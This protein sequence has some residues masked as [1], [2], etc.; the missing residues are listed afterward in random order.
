LPEGARFGVYLAYIYYTNL[1]KKIRSAPADRV[2]Q[3]R[4]RVPN[5]RKAVLLFSSAL[6][7]SLNL[8]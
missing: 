8:L 4:I 2:T 3:E 5:R 7:N 6:R 1:F